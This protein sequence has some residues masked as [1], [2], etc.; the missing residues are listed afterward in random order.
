MVSSAQAYNTKQIDSKHQKSRSLGACL[1][2]LSQAILLL[3][4]DI[5]IT[6]SILKLAKVC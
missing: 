3:G 4:H 6:F 5:D 2:F 1:L